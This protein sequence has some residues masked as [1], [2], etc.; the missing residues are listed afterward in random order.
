LRTTPEV[1]A[2]EDTALRADIT[3]NRT[4]RFPLPPHPI[5]AEQARILVKI[6]LTA[7]KIN[8]IA[9]NAVI[10]VAEL[11]TNAMKFGDVFQLALS[12]RGDAVLIEVQ[13][14][15]EACPDRRRQSVDRVNGRGLLLVEACAKD[16]G[17][18]PEEQ[19]GKTVWAIIDARTTPAP[20]G[21]RM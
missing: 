12:R 15:S 2:G 7:W 18:H 13:D 20:P 14:S 1:P 5:A 21:A 10:I 8:D 17:W 9:D 11:V 19:G 4:Y 16:W 6:A 3:E